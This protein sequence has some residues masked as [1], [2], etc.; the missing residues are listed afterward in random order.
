MP[1]RKRPVED[2]DNEEESHYVKKP[3]NEKSKSLGKGSDSDGNAYWEISK[4]R[5]VSSSTFKGSTFIN[6]RE[7][8]TTADGES[9]PGKKGISLSIEQYNAFLQII[10][11]LNA[12]LHSQGIA[13]AGSDPSGIT[14]PA[15]SVKAKK[16][17]DKKAA[18]G[19]RSNIEETSDEEEAEE[20]E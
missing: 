19:K 6:I 4:N 3:K 7:Y 11:E 18:K 15:V 2:D 14:A 13:V 20:D 16:P 1:P 9:K 5:R 10:P 12:S 8:Y 17:A